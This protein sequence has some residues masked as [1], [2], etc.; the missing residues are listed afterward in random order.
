M[1]THDFLL[2]LGK[3]SAQAAV[4]AVLVFLVQLLFRKQLSPGWRAAL[5]LLVLLRLLPFSL[6]SHT[7]LFNALPS[8]T[9]T[10]PN[11]SSAAAR[12]NELSGAP[13]ATSEPISQLQLSE[14]AEKTPTSQALTHAPR[15]TLSEYLFLIWATGCALFLIGTFLSTWRF[16]RNLRHNKRLEDPA[17]LSLLQDCAKA[18]GLRRLPD[19]QECPALSSPA[20]YGWQ[21]PRLLLPPG[22]VHSFSSEQLRFIFLHELAHLRRRD[23][24]LAWISSLLLALHWFNPAV[25]FALKRWRSDREEA[26]DAMALEA[27]GCEQRLAYGHTML[28]MLEQVNAQ[29][30]APGALGILENRKELRRRVSLIAS[31]VPRRGWPVLAVVLTGG[32]AAVGLTDAQKAELPAPDSPPQASMMESADK[33]VGKSTE[34][35]RISVESKAT[36]ENAAAIKDQALLDYAAKLAML[37]ESGSPDAFLDSTSP[38]KEDW[39]KARESASNDPEANAPEKWETRRKRTQEIQNKNTLNFLNIA[40]KAGLV[41]RR[42]QLSAVQSRRASSKAIYGVGASRIEVPVVSIRALQ[43]VT[44]DGGAE[45]TIEV[46]IN[47]LERFPSGYCGGLLRWKKLPENLNSEL[48]TEIGLLNKLG[49]SVVTDIQES[50]DIALSAFAQ[51][52]LAWLKTDDTGAFLEQVFPSEKDLPL[53]AEIFGGSQAKRMAEKLGSARKDLLTMAGDF[54]ASAKGKG[55]DLSKAQLKLKNISAGRARC[56]DF[57]DVKR[58]RA[59][60]LRIVVEARFPSS[61][62]NAKH[63]GIFVFETGDMMRTLN[64]WYLAEPKLLLKEMPGDGAERAYKALDDFGQYISKNMPLVPGTSVSGLRLSKLDASGTVSL[65]DYRGKVLVLGFWS[66][67]DESCQES[68]NSLQ[69]L[70]E[71]KPAWK[72]KVAVLSVNMDAQAEKVRE[73]LGAQAWNKTENFWAGQEAMASELAKTL[74]LKY[75][76][77]LCIVDKQ[78]LLVALSEPSALE[79]RLSDIIEYTLTRNADEAAAK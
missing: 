53:I 49:G 67:S 10:E 23:I 45:Q 68:M 22:I 7:S 27:A 57:D 12:P 54:Q 28:Q 66:Y 51:N 58:I 77:M 79:S 47:R 16:S 71:D 29:R 75:V 19:L 5:W 31:Y 46:E 11:I 21:Q 52:L 50:D 20:V 78:G 70:L 25:W 72:D 43:F 13:E 59:T 2:L 30:F 73:T 38:K 65:G 24:P 15:W 40:K 64:R 34:S 76:P 1:N 55:L 35:P 4:L 63:N 44:K 48:R 6:G 74:R 32:L 17:L 8:W 42:F 3:S 26:C 56:V 33:D 37:I 14:S 39:L 62:P 61:Y 18:I 41:G 9:Q 36:V 60:K 69:T